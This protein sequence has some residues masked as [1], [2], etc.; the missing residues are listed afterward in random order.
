MFKI[1]RYI[2][3]LLIVFLSTPVCIHAQ[4][5]EITAEYKDPIE[6]EI[7]G[8]RVTGA[9]FSDENA[10]I[11]IA[12]FKIGDKIRFPG[13]D[14]PR[15]MKALW[16][17]KLFTD[18]KIYKEKTIGDVIF[19]EIAVQERPRYSKHSFKNLKKSQHDDVNAIINK[20][21]NKG[22][23]V[24]ENTKVEVS[25]ALKKHFIDKGY[26]DA[27]VRI[28]EDIDK[29]ATNAVQLVFDIRRNRR[30]KI[31]N[32]SYSGNQNVTSAKLRK[33]MEK[34]KRKARIF[35]ASK[36]LDKEY[37]EDKKKIIKYYNKVGYRDARIINDSVWRVKKKDV[38]IHIDINEGNRY[39]F[40]SLAW[41]GNSIYD[42]TLLDNVLGIKKGDIYNNELLENRLRYSQDSRDVSS[43]YMDNGY[44][45]FN[46]D[47]VEV[48][49]DKDS[50]D[51]ELRIF[52]GPQATI[53]RVSIKGNDRTNEHVIRR[54][55]RTK[56]GEK[57]SRSDIIRSQ[58]EII[59][60]GYFNQEKLGINT[61]V[62]AQRGTVDIEYSVEEKPADQ[63]ELSAGWGGFNRG[64]IGTLGVSFNNFSARN[65]MHR[66]TW[67]PLPQGDGQKFSIR[68][69]TNGKFFQSYNASFTEPWLGGKK[70][71][72]LTVSGFRSLI[73]YGAFNSNGI[74]SNKI[75]QTG[76]NISIGSRL[77]KPDDNF[78][79]RAEAD[80]RSMK[81]T[82]W[83]SGGGIGQFAVT[84]G[85]Y[86]NF[87]LRQTLARSSV[88]DPL[89]PREGSNFQ[90]TLMLTPPYSLF[91]SS[92]TDYSTLPVAEKFKWVEYHKW[93][94]N[95]DWYTTIVG[96]L[97]LKSSMKLGMLGSYNKDIGLSPFERYNFGGNGLNNQQIGIIGRDI[98]S[99]RGY[100]PADIAGNYQNGQQ[101]GAA[102]FNKMALE[103][104]YP[105]SLNPQST[106]FVLGFVEGGNAFA[107]IKQFNP[108][109]LRRSAGLGLRVFLP[110]FG[111]L[112]FD[113]GIGFDKTG[114]ED[115]SL[116]NRG[117]FNII[118]GF[119]PD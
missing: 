1:K 43:L 96:K 37:Q 68:G 19:L 45:F 48:A 117:T 76:G 27:D 31:Q 55:L 83:T 86:N 20:M 46:V 114:I 97:V 26:L 25:T 81:L 14:I 56:P 113:Y 69:Q 52:E 99:S 62:N 50:I 13:S 115:T 30:V 10:L 111:L 29:Q 33:Q 87:S 65:I 12:G 36:Y 61:P 101:Y 108:F 39:Y 22:T 72:S 4:Q 49:I 100:Q 38:K 104:R 105:I 70:A 57:F 91:R 47:P 15:A 106:I 116:K 44:L 8:I 24:T 80:I 35:S 77:K 40:R 103:L 59:N 9:Q 34:T 63:L 88:N 73:N 2:Y 90:L 89:F 78:V 93:R 102:V 110:M 7:G 53:D 109:E 17:L 107:S 66:E 92:E 32:I 41:K 119:E 58:R 23:I 118:L 28:K 42:N 85:T 84:D 51:I 112:G 75:T 18:V 11:N 94:F 3:L 64:I 21:L 5:T 16:K 98:I 95:A 6:Y 82:A 74:E 60:L 54:E 71:T 67:S 79:Y